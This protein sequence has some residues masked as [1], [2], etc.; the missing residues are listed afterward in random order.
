MRFLPLLLCLI[1]LLTS[2]AGTMVVSDVTRFHSL[3]AKGTGQS[4]KFVNKEH[5]GELAFRSSASLV[6]K[7]LVE[8]GWVEKDG[9]PAD[10]TV[11][12]IYGADKSGHTAMG[13]QAIIGQTGGGTTYHSGTI[14]SFGTGY[15]TYSGTSY[16]PATFGVVGEEYYTYTVWGRF[17][18]LTIAD[19]KGKPV[20]QSRVISTG[21]TPDIYVVL[22]NMVDALFEDF[23]GPN[24]KSDHIEGRLIKP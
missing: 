21:P 10:Y 22:A 19:A 7:H 13:S 8:Y 16:T 11:T 9:G 5:I 24:G 15:A 14:N 3:P 23:P 12:F 6:A 4:F 20:F 2:C 17:L 18:V 1:A